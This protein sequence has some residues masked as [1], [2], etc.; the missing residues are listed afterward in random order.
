M[1]IQEVMV[2]MLAKAKEQG[3]KKIKLG[4]PN[5]KENEVTLYNIDI[6]VKA[7]YDWYSGNGARATLTVWSE[8][9]HKMTRYVDDYVDDIVRWYL[10][11]EDWYT[12]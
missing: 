9:D 10:L 2:E 5:I 4:L 1:K 8:D 3:I 11:S 6:D 7:A 12:C